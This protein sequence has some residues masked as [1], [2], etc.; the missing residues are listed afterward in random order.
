MNGGKEVRMKREVRKLVV[1]KRARENERETLDEE[2]MKHGFDRR[3]NSTV[4]FMSH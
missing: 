3:F 2:G 1:R 4:S